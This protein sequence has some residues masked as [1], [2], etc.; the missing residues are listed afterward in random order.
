MS[1]VCSVCA[2]DGSENFDMLLTVLDEAQS[3]M[4]ENYDA[5]ARIEQAKYSLEAVVRP[6]IEGAEI[7]RSHFKKQ[8]DEEACHCLDHLN[9]DPTRSH[10]RPPNVVYPFRKL[11]YDA[12]GRE[13][14]H[15][16]SCS[17]CLEV[18]RLA[19][20][21]GQII[22]TMP[23]SERREQLGEMVA[24]IFSR[25]GLFRYIGHLARA[26]AKAIAWSEE[27]ENLGPGEFAQLKDYGSKRLPRHCKEEHVCVHDLYNRRGGEY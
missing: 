4:C 10:G 5:L 20:E 25:D 17:K 11:C 12:S 8:C 18:D 27:V 9:S 1:C 2:Q 21:C 19:Y 16:H 15:K 13:V 6:F 7:Q 23:E 3:L 24:F 22:G 14:V 26:T